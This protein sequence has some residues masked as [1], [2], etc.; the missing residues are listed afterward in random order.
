MLGSGSLVRSSSPSS[1][2]AQELAFYLS[3]ASP[4]SPSSPS[5]SCPLVPFRTGNFGAVLVTGNLILSQVLDP[6]FRLLA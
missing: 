4:Y 2:V 6:R 5:S 1:A 3:T